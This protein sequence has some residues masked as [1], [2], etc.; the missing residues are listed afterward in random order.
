MKLREGKLIPDIQTYHQ[1]MLLAILTSMLKLPK[2]ME[3]FSFLYAE[4]DRQMVYDFH[5]DL[6]GVSEIIR[7]RNV[8]RLYPFYD[9]DPD[10][11][12]ISMSA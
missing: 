10:V 8:Y 5:D 12:E 6:K 9:M 4:E 2:L 7:R 11:L 1:M 3:D